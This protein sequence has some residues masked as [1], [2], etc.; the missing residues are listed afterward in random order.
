MRNKELEEMTQSELL[1]YY[2]ENKKEIIRLS[3]ENEK[4]KE[5][6]KSDK[7]KNIYFF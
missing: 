5:K 2:K 4:L 1:N 3:N 7:K 6:I